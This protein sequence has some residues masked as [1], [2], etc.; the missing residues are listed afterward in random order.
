MHFDN[1]YREKKVPSPLRQTWYHFHADSLAMIGLYGVAALLLLCLFGS[2]LAPYGLDQQF[3][4]YQLLPPPGR[5][6]AT[7]PS[8]SAPTISG[9]ICS[10]ACCAARR[11]P[12]APR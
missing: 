5:A 1:V 7:S 11:R 3:L 12:L 8:S 4:G 10:A 2:L 9:A 6:M